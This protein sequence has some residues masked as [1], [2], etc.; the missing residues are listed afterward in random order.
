MLYFFL[1]FRKK[2][3][4]KK[5]DI[6]IF[7]NLDERFEDEYLQYG[8]VVSFK[9][10]ETPFMGDELHKNFYIVLSG[11]IKTFQINMESSKELTLSIYRKGDMFDVLTLL[12]GKSHDVLYEVLERVELLELPIE[13]V[14]EW[15]K[16]N[17]TFNKHFFPYVATQL[18]RQEEL[19]SDLALYSTSERL[20][21]L[22]IQNINPKDEY[23]QLLQNLSKTEIAKLL[24]TVRHVVERHLKELENNQV[25]ENSRKNIY[26]KDI[27]QLL[28]KSNQ[29]LLEGE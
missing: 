8:K 23:F 2:L 29:L 19:S 5:Y 17:E 1:K 25:I 22:L 24:G 21:K 13:K 12:D 7:Q 18:R 11:K 14:R 10:K 15:L 4:M 20:S 28:E 3:K 9:K 27:E 6:E 26:V 16:S